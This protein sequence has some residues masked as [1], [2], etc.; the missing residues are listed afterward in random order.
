MILYNYKRDFST[1][2]Y[3]AEMHLIR[4]AVRPQMAA[5]PA[6]VLMTSGEEMRLNLAHKPPT[7]VLVLNRGSQGRN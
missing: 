6:K 4:I 2:P 5:R 3:S 7:T 1:D